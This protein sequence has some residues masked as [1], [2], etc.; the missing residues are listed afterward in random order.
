MVFAAAVLAF[1]SGDMARIR[2]VVAVA[3]AKLET[4]RA[5]SS[6]LGWLAY[7]QASQ[8]IKPLLATAD[9]VL[10]RVGIA[11]SALHR[12]NPG[13]ALVEALASDDPLLRAR[14]CRAAG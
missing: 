4:V 9:P 8:Q 6:A 1:E 11:A 7:E 10:R 2:D 12:R 14:A 5:L 13:P 3:T